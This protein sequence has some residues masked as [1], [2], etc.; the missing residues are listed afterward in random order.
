MG[1]TTA[2]AEALAS[3]K[4][5]K[6]HCCKVGELV[7][8]L[9]PD[10]RADAVAAVADV[11]VG[12]SSIAAALVAALKQAGHDVDMAPSTVGRHRQMNHEMA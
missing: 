6:E 11:T 4:K 2:F 7:D 1:T 5:T 12:H 3:T 8:L 9:D 10:S